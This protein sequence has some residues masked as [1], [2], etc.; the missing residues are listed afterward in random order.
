MT[1]KQLIQYAKL[2]GWS[3]DDF[4]KAAT[5]LLTEATHDSEVVKSNCVICGGDKVIFGEPCGGCSS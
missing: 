5:L 2:W 3:R 1:P 4:I